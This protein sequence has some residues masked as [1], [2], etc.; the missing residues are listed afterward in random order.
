[1]IFCK[2]N[3]REAEGQLK[4]SLKTVLVCLEGRKE[5]EARTLDV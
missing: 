2:E 4:R 3:C 5:G 1:M